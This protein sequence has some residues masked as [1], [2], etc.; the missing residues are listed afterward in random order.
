VDL[1]ILSNTKADMAYFKSYYK[2][3]NRDKIAEKVREEG[4]DPIT[5]KN[6]PGFVYAKHKHPETKLLAI[7][8]G[9]MEVDVGGKKV[10]LEKYDRLI[11][12]GSVYHSAVV[13][14]DGCEFYW[15]EKI[16]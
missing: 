8:S 4:F 12:P 16:I 1:S 5:I 3:Q 2:G 7:L 11:I 10:K 14:A 6:S 9:S 13:G 15:A